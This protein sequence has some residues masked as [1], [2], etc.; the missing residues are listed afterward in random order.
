MCKWK[1]NTDKL[2]EKW[3]EKKVEQKIDTQPT[4]VLGLTWNRESN[5]FGFDLTSILHESKDTCNTKRH[6]LQ[7]ASRLFNPIGFLSQFIVRVK[8]LF[9][10]TWECG[11]EWDEELPTDLEL[12]LISG[13]MNSEW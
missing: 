4:K 6:I 13:M 12:K 7:I 8:L 10:E 9:Q 5:E 2:E 1:T 3:N 11:L